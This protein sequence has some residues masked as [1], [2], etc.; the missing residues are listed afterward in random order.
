MLDKR[1]EDSESALVNG[2]EF[3]H[4]ISNCVRRFSK[5]ELSPWHRAFVDVADD[6]V[7]TPLNAVDGVRWNAAFAY[8]DPARERPNLTIRAETLVDRRSP[9]VLL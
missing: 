3:V 6:V 8:L 7:I 9:S 1:H 4:A 5:E 2:C